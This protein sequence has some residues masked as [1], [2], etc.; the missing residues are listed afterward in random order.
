MVGAALSEALQHHEAG[1]L[2]QAQA[3]YR[4]ILAQDPDNADSL[5][6]LGL[7]TAEQGDPAAGAALI[8]RAMALGARARRRTTTTL[9][10]PTDCSAAPR[11]RC[12]N[13]APPSTLRPQS[14]EIHNNLATTLRDLGPACGGG[15]A[16]SPG[17][18]TRAGHRGDLV[19]SGQRPRRA[20]AVPTEVE[21]CFRRA[22]ALKPDFT[23][24]H[25]N[26]GRWLMTQARWA[27]A[28]AR[29]PKPPGWRPAQAPTWNNLGIALQEQGRTEEAE[30]CYRRALALAAALRHRALQS[31]LPA[32][33]ARPDG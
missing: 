27:E 32:A 8:Q 20:R 31:W 2:G 5:H 9:P 28:E 3:L 23:N 16:L 22:V 30:A 11:T 25:A 17:R 6:L 33:G 7:I 26:Y 15:G 12:A 21:A 4:D 29:L 19:Q 13:T 10:C 1:R 24:A 18:R 14:A